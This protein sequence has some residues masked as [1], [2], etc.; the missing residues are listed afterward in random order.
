MQPLQSEAAYQKLCV[1]RNVA[2]VCFSL[3]LTLNKRVQNRF[4]WWWQAALERCHE[5]SAS[6]NVDIER[7]PS[8]SLFI[9]LDHNDTL[10]ANIYGIFETRHNA[11]PLS[12]TS[13]V[14]SQIVV[15]VLL[16][17]L[18]KL[19]FSVLRNMSMDLS[20]PSFVYLKSGAESIKLTVNRSEEKEVAVG[21]VSVSCEFLLADEAVIS[22]L[23]SKYDLPKSVGNCCTSAKSGDTK[24]LWWYKGKDFKI[25]LDWINE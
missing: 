23:D 25:H 6:N 18:I 1:V 11:L 13:E 22:K 24:M 17:I 2:G 3:T 5:L 10:V 7:L 9:V 19:D 12:F 20:Y 14:I 4:S 8:G 15:I 16:I 21:W